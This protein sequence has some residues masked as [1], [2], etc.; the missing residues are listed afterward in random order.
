MFY[1]W[2]CIDHACFCVYVHLLNLSSLYERK[3]VAFVFW[4]SLT[5][6][7]MMSSNC[8]YLH[9]VWKTGHWH[10][11]HY[12]TTG[13]LWLGSGRSYKVNTVKPLQAHLP[14]FLS[15]ISVK[16]IAC[17]IR[18]LIETVAGG[19]VRD[20]SEAWKWGFILYNNFP[21]YQ[22]RLG[23]WDNIH[24][25]VTIHLRPKDRS[26]KRPNLPSHWFLTPAFRIE[27]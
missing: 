21:L 25:R 11:G 23:H 4:T 13:K 6:L 15:K 3:H 2:V 5:S 18:F 17:S 12:S 20:L 14:Q 26:Q 7:N 10:L 24:W 16:M 8:I 9:M 1:L 27:S 22:K 19:D